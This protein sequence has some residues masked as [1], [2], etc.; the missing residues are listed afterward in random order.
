[1]EIK[2]TG[3]H[4]Q[5]DDQVK[6]YAEGKLAKLTRFLDEPVDVNLTLET[7]KHRQIAELLVSHRHGMV[8][9]T[10][11]AA[12]MLDAIHAVAEKAEKQARRSRKKHMDKRRRAQRQGD[13]GWHWPLEVLEAQSVGS[14]TTP[15]V[16]KTTRL[17]IKPMTIDEAA[18]DLDTSKNEFRVFLDSATDRVSVLYRRNDGHYGLIAPEF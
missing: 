14:G 2:Y 1:M 8:Q 7:E 4:F 15:R 16:I 13:D 9:A 5:V 17:P 12:Q 3:R 10:E 18:L 11:E 6:A